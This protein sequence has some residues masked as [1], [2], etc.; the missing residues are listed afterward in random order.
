M[1]KI[2]TCIIGLALFLFAFAGF[3]YANVDITLKINGIDGESKIEGHED[4]IDVLSWDWGVTQ[5]GSMHVGG[6]GGS[7]IADVEDLQ[8]IKYID[9]SSV[10][11]LRKC[12]NGALLRKA[13]LT[14]RKS[15]DY[16]IDY[17]VITLSPVLVTSVSA[18]GDGGM[19][20]LTEV[21][22]LNFNKVKFSYTPQKEDGSPDA[23]IDFTWNIEKNV[24]E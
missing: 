13:V 23:T 11:L 5:S 10:N 12:F 18:G 16:P 9:K 24:E 1:K 6:G 15:G 2:F 22:T 8:I 19:D 7:G 20:R 21:V 17:M 14:V 4:E 3:S